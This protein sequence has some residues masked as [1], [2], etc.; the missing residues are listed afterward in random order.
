MVVETVH[1][2]AHARRQNDGMFVLCDFV[3][4]FGGNENEGNDRFEYSSATVLKGEYARLDSSGK[5][6]R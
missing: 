6:G 4:K 2:N 1:E 3:G 5:T